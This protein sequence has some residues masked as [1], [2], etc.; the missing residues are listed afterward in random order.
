MVQWCNATF[1]EASVAKGFNVKK[2]DG[3]RR[4]LTNE[5]R[6]RAEG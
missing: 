2:K 6:N 1:A 4:S 5:V 3:E